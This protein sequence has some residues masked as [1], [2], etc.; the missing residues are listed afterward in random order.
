V[1]FVIEQ[2]GPRIYKL[3]GELDAS[4]VASADGVLEAEMPLSEDLTLDLSE[5]T[6]VDTMG[7]S[8]FTSLSQKL[9]GLG[10]LILFS[11][12]HSV[13][14]V[15]ELVGLHDRPNVEISDPPP[16]V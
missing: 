4:N 11:P 15:L 1:D 16:N 9:E 7:I 6:F 13:R 14:T 8:L 3:I 12:D 10:K 2:V 5:L